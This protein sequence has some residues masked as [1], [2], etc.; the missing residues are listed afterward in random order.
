MRDVRRAVEDGLLDD[1][2]GRAVTRIIAAG[3]DDPL[4][5]QMVSD[6]VHR[7]DIRSA[8]TGGITLPKLKHGVRGV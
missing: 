4:I 1:D 3:M 2:L 6:R 5:R 8:F 7:N